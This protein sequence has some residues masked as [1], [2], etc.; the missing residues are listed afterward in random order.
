MTANDIIHRNATC[1]RQL[2]EA[3][4]EIDRLTK[5]LDYATDDTNRNLLA[6]N[7]RLRIENGRLRAELKFAGDMLRVSN[8][9]PSQYKLGEST[10]SGNAEFP[11]KRA[12]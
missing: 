10:E 11:P 6:E 8:P 3:G 9:P 7:D 5:L 12:K 4:A 1:A 2:L